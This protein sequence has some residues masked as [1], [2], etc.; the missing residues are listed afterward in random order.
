MRNLSEGGTPEAQHE[1]GTLGATELTAYM[2][3][4]LKFWA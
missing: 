1:G 4:S 3:P 2:T